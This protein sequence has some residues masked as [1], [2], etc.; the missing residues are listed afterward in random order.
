MVVLINLK[1]CSQNL[2]TVK[3]EILSTVDQFFVEPKKVELKSMD[4]QM[5]N[6]KLVCNNCSFFVDYQF[7]FGSIP[8]YE[9]GNL[10]RKIYCREVDIYQLGL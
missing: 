4:G 6:K 5:I 2:K 9:L 1:D 8:I 10:L 7:T 3:N